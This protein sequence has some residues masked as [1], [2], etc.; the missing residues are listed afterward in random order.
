MAWWG[1]WLQPKVYL[2][3]VSDAL[4]SMAACRRK[5]S[6]QIVISDSQWLSLVKYLTIWIWLIMDESWWLTG[7]NLSSVS[8]SWTAS[9]LRQPHPAVSHA[10]ISSLSHQKNTS[11]WLFK[12]S[13]RSELFENIW[14]N[15]CWKY[16]TTRSF[17]IMT[18]TKPSCSLCDVS[19]DNSQ[20]HRVH[21]KSEAQ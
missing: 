11:W 18:S 10:I 20:E 13:M 2:V 1:W 4:L 15:T 14:L 17:E 8:K 3:T 6:Y 21:A 12:C 16:H 7:F 9:W 5:R 19:F